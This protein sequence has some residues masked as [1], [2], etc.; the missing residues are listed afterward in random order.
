MAVADR[1]KSVPGVIGCLGGIG[2]TM[3]IFIC[4]L[5]FS[6]DALLATAKLAVLIAS[7]IVAIT[8]LLVGWRILRTSA[9]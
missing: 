1:I 5:A 3:S 7:A 2:F 6:A 9:P 4:E 8:G